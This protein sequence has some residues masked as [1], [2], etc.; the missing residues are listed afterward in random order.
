MTGDHRALVLTDDTATG[1][2]LTR[3]VEPLEAQLFGLQNWPDQLDTTVKVI[4]VDLASGGD[5]DSLL[6]R[7][8]KCDVP[9]IAVLS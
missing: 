3:A 6:R 1:E 2:L 5:R 8:R 9:L 7:L 4:V